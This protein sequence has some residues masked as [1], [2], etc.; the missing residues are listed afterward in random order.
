[1]DGG[2][3][4]FLTC[5]QCGRPVRLEIAKTDERGQAVHEECYELRL[6]GKQSNWPD[7]YCNA[8]WGLENA[9]VAG[10]IFEARAEIANRLVELN[11]L[12]GLHSEERLA[13]S[14]ALQGL[15]SLER[16]DQRHKAA[17]IGKM[18]WEKLSSLTPRFA[19]LA[20]NRT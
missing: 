8:I 19:P 13:I 20:S 18:A 12:P 7:A 15:R 5:V 16:E 4:S 2:E 6:Y 11:N 14:E 17:E 9:L 3:I 1:M 10:Y